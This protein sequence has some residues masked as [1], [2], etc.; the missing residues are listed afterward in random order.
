[1]GCKAENKHHLFG[2]GCARERSKVIE[3]PVTEGFRI[4]VG[5]VPRI[6]FGRLEVGFQGVRD[7]WIGDGHSV[8]DWAG[9]DDRGLL[10]IGAW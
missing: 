5:A 8:G 3:N 2:K 1:M 6:Q 9:Q 7:G 4:V 10:G